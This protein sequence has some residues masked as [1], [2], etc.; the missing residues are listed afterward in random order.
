MAMRDVTVVLL[1]DGM[2]A[3]SI[4]PVEVLSSAGVLWNALQGHPEEPAFRVRT[5]SIDGGPVASACGVGLVPQAALHEVGRTDIVVLAASGADFDRKLAQNRVLVPW[6]AHQHSNGAY[7]AAICSGVVYLAEAGLLD[8][9]VSTS[10]WALCGELARRYPRALWQP[11]RF[12]TEDSRV[13]CSGGVYAAADLSL[14]LVEKFAGH[15]TALECAKAMLLPMPRSHQSSYSMLPVSRPH[16]DGRI[17]IIE[18]NLHAGLA[19]SVCT[20]ELANRAG[21]GVRT[22]IR[23]FKAATGKSPA[24]YVQALRV[25]A[26]KSMLEAGPTPIQSISTQVGYSDLAFFRALFKRETGMTPA[27]YRAEFAPLA[28][29]GTHSPPEQSAAMGGVAPGETFSALARL[30]RSEG[31]SG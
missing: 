21:M 13:L 19:E 24:E 11:D 5:A 20:P 29:S 1:E 25:A 18:E 26:A 7:I 30:P 22:F 6:L 4:T 31:R 17:R 2:A 14:Y 10:H 8:G 9:R 15:R 28:V 23:R 3:T 12:V 27:E 16:D